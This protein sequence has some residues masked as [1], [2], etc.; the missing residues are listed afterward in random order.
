[1]DGIWV[2]VLC[3]ML[4]RNSVVCGD[5]NCINDIYGGRTSL[6]LTSQRM[7]AATTYTHTYTNENLLAWKIFTID[8]FVSIFKTHNVVGGV[9]YYIND[10]YGGTLPVLKNEIKDFF[11]TAN[12]KS[13]L[14]TQIRKKFARIF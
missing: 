8:I 5:V 1:M 13:N 11:L 7:P 10:I 3:S 6:F 14:H 12:L 2:K 4:Y 9:V